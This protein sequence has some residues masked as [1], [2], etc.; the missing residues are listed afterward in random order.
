MAVRDMI[1]TPIMCFGGYK[2]IWEGLEKQHIFCAEFGQWPRP[3]GQ[4]PVAAATNVSG[5]GHRPKLTK[6]SVFSIFVERL[7]KPKS[8]F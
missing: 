5:R 7:K 2:I 3:V 8:L 6:F 1:L 4:R